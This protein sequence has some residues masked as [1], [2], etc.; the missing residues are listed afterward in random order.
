MKKILL[1]VVLSFMFC[2]NVNATSL[3]L[4]GESSKITVKDTTPTVINLNIKDIAEGTD[5]NR[6][7]FDFSYDKEKLALDVPNDQY[8][9]PISITG[10]S[11]LI[12]KNPVKE[13]IEGTIM[14]FNL[15]NLAEEDEKIELTL[16]NV[17][18]DDQTLEDIVLEVNLKKEVKTTQR[19]KSTSAALTSFKVNNGATVKPAFSKDVYEYKI[20][21]KDTIRDLTIS[22]SYEQNPVVMDVECTLGCNPDSSLPN[23]L[24]LIPGKNEATFKFTSE[25]EKDEKTYKFIIY[26]GPTTDGSNLLA[27]LSVEEFTLKEDFDKNKLDYTV[28]VPYETEKVNVVANP[29]DGNADVKIKGNDSLDVGDNV[30]TITV[31]SAETTEKKIY[32]ITVTRVEFKP[33]EEVTTDTVTPTLEQPAPTKITKNN[34]IKLIIIIGLVSTLIIGIAAYFIFFYKGKKKDEMPKVSKPKNN[35]QSAI[36]DEDKEPTSVEEALEDLMKTKEITNKD[37]ELK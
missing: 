9:H 31:T 11:I 8:G 3:E 5:V 36:V 6:I 4:K 30:I 10:D 37:N 28:T 34:N 32:N 1:A 17:V 23:K 20:Y 24:K 25:D 14:S 2:I 15:T 18:I 29:E 7:S 21:V 13:M 22:P 26:R 16:K 19:A 27:S 33:D 12:V 35:L